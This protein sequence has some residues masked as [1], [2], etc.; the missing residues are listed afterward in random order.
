MFVMLFALLLLINTFGNEN[1]SVSSRVL[2][3]SS[4]HLLD[5]PSFGFY[6]D[7]SM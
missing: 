1:S 5:V 2:V 3:S 4:A 6:G 7:V